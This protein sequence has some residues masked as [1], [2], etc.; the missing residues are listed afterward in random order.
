MYAYCGNNPVM[1][2]D[3]MG[4]WN[5]RTF[6]KESVGVIV[7]VVAYIPSKAYHYNRNDNQEGYINSKIAEDGIDY[8]IDNWEEQLYEKNRYH[9]HTIG[10]QGKE[11]QFNKKY[12]SLDNKMEVIINFVDKDN[13]YLV[14]D[15]F[16]V[17]TYNFGTS[18]VTHVVKDVI[19][20]YLWGNGKEDSDIKIF[21]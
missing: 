10:E 11:A 21:F 18:P 7:G 14:T 2:Y 9:R 8:F 12:M 17:G 13:P 5:W 4:T 20:Y 19:P 1:G 6:W 16:N 3:P 15:P